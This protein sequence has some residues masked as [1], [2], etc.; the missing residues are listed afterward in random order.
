MF[1]SPFGESKIRKLANDANQT[2]VRKGF[3]SPFGESKIRKFYF[4]KGVEVKV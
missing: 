4:W 3:Q 2:L 1:Q